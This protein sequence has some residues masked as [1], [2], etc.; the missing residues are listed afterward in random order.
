MAQCQHRGMD[1]AG[2]RPLVH[3]FQ[4]R[5]SPEPHQM[6]VFVLSFRRHH[7]AA[8]RAAGAGRQPTRDAEPTH[9]YIPSMAASHWR[10]TPRHGAVAIAATGG[11]EGI[12][13]LDGFQPR[14]AVVSLKLAWG[15]TPTRGN[16][17]HLSLLLS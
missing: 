5:W 13:P 7:P 11:V 8:R 14:P 15:R 10:K 6:D 1:T 17:Y 3:Q 16:L 2:T 12:L 4:L 9:R